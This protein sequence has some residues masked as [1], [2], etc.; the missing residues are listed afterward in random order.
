MTIV[1]QQAHA[2]IRQRAGVPKDR[3]GRKRHGFRPNRA[4][5]R[6]APAKPPLYD[7]HVPDRLQARA[8]LRAVRVMARPA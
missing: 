2:D 3:G 4:G 1:G 6:R 7:P 8:E 5:D